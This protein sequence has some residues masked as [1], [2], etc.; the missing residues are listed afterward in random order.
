[1]SACLFFVATPVCLS[2]IGVCLPGNQQPSFLHPCCTLLSYI[3]VKAFDLS[4]HPF[5]LS[6]SQRA[7][8]AGALLC[9]LT[10]QDFGNLTEHQA[11][12]L[13]LSTQVEVL[14]LD[15]QLQR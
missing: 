13:M 4:H 11:K 12:R 8:L 3:H 6:P 15:A 1:M 2:D 9:A 10:R 7:A 14:K 5:L